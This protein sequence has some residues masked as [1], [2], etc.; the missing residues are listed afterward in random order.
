MIRFAKLFE[1]L[2]CTTS[3]NAKVSAMRKFF[4]SSSQED[5]VWALFFLSG[6]RIKRMISSRK[7]RSWLREESPLP[8]WLINE[9]AAAVGDTAE[10]VSLLNNKEG[11]TSQPLTLSEWMETRILPLKDLDEASQKEAVFQ[12]WQEL[13]RREQF[14]F[15]KILTGGFRVGV[16]KQLATKA[17]SETLGVSK[18]ELLLRLMGD[19]TPSIDFYASLSDPERESGLRPYPFYLASPLDCPAEELGPIEDWHTEAKW[20]GIRCQA[21]KRGDQIAL[22]S[23]SGELI[24]NTFPEVVEAMQDADPSFVLDGELLVM[25]G[26]RPRPFFE[27]QARLGRKKVSAKLLKSHPVTFLAFD[28]LELNGEDLRDAPL[29]KRLKALNVISKEKQWKVSK[30][31]IFKS[32]EDAGWL[33]ENA[34]DQNIEGLMLKKKSSPYRTGRVKGDWWKFKTDPFE[35][36]AVLIYAQPGSGRRSNLYTDYTF[37]V[38]EGD[39]LVPIAKAYSG[40]S[41]K[42][43]DELDKW[44]RK[45]TIE[46]FGPVRSV[47]PTHVFELHFEGVQPS[48]RHKSGVAVRFPRISKWRKDKTIEEAGTLETLQGMI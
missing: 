35:I 28:L 41:Q 10:L 45:N 44:I 46:R 24:T 12:Y 33:R 3:T 8:D 13:S 43:I 21:V 15:N 16:S 38:W 37:A 23:R 29:K 14:I 42:E 9:C 11:T 20:D 34:R 32:W 22:W 25:D 2:D 36:D 30:P 4:E 26:E 27:L 48:S 7:L 17:L 18:E 47:E 39:Q 19:W 40:L 1:D 6:K 31:F 5:A